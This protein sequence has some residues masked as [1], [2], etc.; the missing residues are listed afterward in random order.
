VAL[1]PLAVIASIGH[2]TDRTLLDEVAAVSCS[3]PTHAAEAAAPLNCLDAR[4]VLHV[5][6]RRLGDHAR[7]AVV[8]RARLLSALSRAPAAHLARHRRVLHQSLRELRA[9]SRRIVGD[10]LARTI[11]RT[12]TLERCRGGAIRDCALRRPSELERLRLALGAHDPERTLERGYALVSDTGGEP[13]TTV[14]SAR[15]A[16]RVRLRFADGS[17]DATVAER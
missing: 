5:A 6:A 13:V 1:L 10:E 14:A 12:R 7:E 8:A 15:A 11:E 16:G 17:A 9:V 4:L 2:H 3:T